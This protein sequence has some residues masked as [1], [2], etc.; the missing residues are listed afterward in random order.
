MIAKANPD[1]ILIIDR[2]EAIGAD[3]LEKAAFEND[4]IKSTSAYKNGGIVYLQAD[5]WY[6]SG[7]GLDSL[8]KQIEA[9]E[10]A[11]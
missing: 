7:G 4:V 11:L 6:L 5:L 8:T 2:S 3:K 1:V 9:V 10:N